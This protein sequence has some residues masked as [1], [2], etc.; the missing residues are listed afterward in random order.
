MAA[1]RRRSYNFAQILESPGKVGTLRCD[2]RTAQRTVPSK[3][4]K[5]GTISHPGL[6]FQLSAFSIS[7][8]AYMACH[9]AQLYV[10]MCD[11]E[12]LHALYFVEPPKARNCAV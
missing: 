7:A 9:V 8:F 12:S 4:K 1:N 10:A 5:A 3:N 6:R 2:D 11:T